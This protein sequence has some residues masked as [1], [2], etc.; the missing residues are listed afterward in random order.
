MQPVAPGHP[1]ASVKRAASFILLT[2]YALITFGCGNSSPNS[3]L[4]GPASAQV[5]VVQGGVN[6]G[7]VDVLVNGAKAQTRANPLAT[8]PYFAVT[9]SS[10]HVEEVSSGT[11][12]PAILDATYPVAASSF[13][14]VMTVGDEAKGTLAALALVDDH[15][16]PPTG[17]IKLRI[18]NGA[19]TIGAVDLYVNN[20][21]DVFPS[22]PTVAGLTFKSSSAYLPLSASNYRICMMPAG[23]SPSF[24]FIGTGTPNCSL[25]LTVD[26]GSGY[27]NFTFAIFDPPPPP[28][29][30]S[31][32]QFVV[33][34]PITVLM[35]LQQ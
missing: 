18:V 31:P 35:D 11:T 23:T 4:T 5:R 22:A 9:G 13:N 28:T 12:G 17:Q 32:G 19:S 10:I 29:G 30:G 21:G 27:R 20:V 1:E 15:T 8:P 3:M 25:N 2:I 24:A 6:S 33:G 34:I 14:T 7:I 26:I 16:A